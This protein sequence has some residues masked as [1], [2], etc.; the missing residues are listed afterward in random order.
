MLL[1]LLRSFFRLLADK[2]PRHDAQCHRDQHVRQ[3]VADRNVDAHEQAVHDET[4]HPDDQVAPVEGFLRS[5]ALEDEEIRDLHRDHRRKNGADE[6]QEVGDVIHG[7][8]DRADRTDHGHADADPAAVQLLRD[9]LAGNAGRVRIEERGC[10]RGKYDDQK[11]DNTEAGLHHDLRDVRLRRKDGG[12]HADHVHPAAD[13]AVDDRAD[14]RCTHRLFR[15]AGVIADQRK[16][17]QRHG[18]RQFHSRAEGQSVVGNLMHDAVAED[19]EAQDHGQDEQRRHG[20]RVHLAQVLDADEDPQDDQAADHKAPHPFDLL[21]PDPAGS[22]RAVVDHDGRPA[23]QLN[24][25][26]DGEQQAALRAEAHL[27]D[28]HRTLAD[29]AADQTGEEQHDAADHMA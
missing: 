8:Q 28:L 3:R 5:V 1:C 21:A 11:S 23:H 15:V 9:G 22:A 18:N 17:R 19:N 6:V 25:V 24:D 20:H 2:Q 27:R 12:A 14:R 13:D 29:F 10:Y 4:D 16:P 7:E 26:E